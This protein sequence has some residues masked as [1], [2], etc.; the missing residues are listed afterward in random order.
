[1][2][3]EIE[4]RLRRLENPKNYLIGRPAGEPLRPRNILIFHR[5]WKKQLQPE[6][7]FLHQHHRY[8]LITAIRGRGLIGVDTKTHAIREGQ[9]LLMLP[10]QTHWYENM[11]SQGIS[12]S[13]VTF[14]HERDRRLE[15]LRDRG[16]VDGGEDGYLELREVL[17]CWQNPPQADLLGTRLAI[18]LHS[19][20]RSIKRGRAERGVV[21]YSEGGEWVGRVNRFVF[22]N[23]EKP[24]PVEEIARGLR[25]SPSLLRSKFRRLT[26]KSV[27]K[28]VRGLKLQYACE[29]LHDTKLQVNEVAEQCG[30]DSLFS[31]SRA[32]QSCYKISPSGYRKK[33]PQSP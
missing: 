4:L 1:M 3:A 13:F 21:E 23:R 32:F 29:L 28:Y 19:L 27:G 5:R 20:A 15:Q 31:F 33:F 12:W 2:I 25:V 7:S 26:G 30:Y 24:L 9:S 22:E 17:R 18:W 16:A 11:D 14:E 10:F 6:P 8:V